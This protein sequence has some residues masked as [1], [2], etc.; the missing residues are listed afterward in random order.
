MG[1]LIELN[2]GK[3][4]Y[5]TYKK[6]IYGEDKSI[7]Y[8]QLRTTDGAEI[9]LPAFGITTENYGMVALVE[10]GDASCSITADVSG[11][12]HG[13]NHASAVF[14][15]TPNALIDTD[16]SMSAIDFQ[17]ELMSCDLSVRYM[18]LEAPY[19][20]SIMANT[21]REYLLESER[22]SLEQVK[23]TSVLNLIGAVT[24][25]KKFMGIKRYVPKALTTYSQAQEI[26][27]WFL[28]SSDSEFDVI[29]EGWGN[30]GIENRLANKALTVKELG[31]KQDFYNLLSDASD[32][33]VHVIPDVNF[34][35]VSQKNA[36]GFSERKYSA[37][38]IQGAVA[39]VVNYEYG[40]M[41]KK[42]IVGD[43]LVAP[44]KLMSLSQSFF[45]KYQQYGASDIY[46][47]AIGTDLNSDF[48]RGNL[49]DREQAKNHIRE[50]LSEVAET[51]SITVSGGNAYA[52]GYAD[53]IVDLPLQSG[54][55]YILDRDIPFLSMVLAGTTELNAL[56]NGEKSD[57]WYT[58]K[59]IEAGV[60]PQFNLIYSDTAELREC[61]TDMLLTSYMA[62]RE[63]AKDI[64]QLVSDALEKV[65]GSC[66]IGH[67]YQENGVS[68]THYENGYSV[69]VNFNDET[70]SA[71][72]K[73][74]E[75]KSWLVINERGE[76]E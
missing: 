67:E 60:W 18:V 24:Y 54:R 75:G 5:E 49:V 31:G 32:K 26:Y 33:G 38:N 30:K 4:Q 58:L 3:T 57:S 1:A 11:R 73:S 55:A 64:T 44:S 9:H 50:F 72:G 25:Q 51:Y 34:M 48:N 28:E 35:Y 43:Y 62:V 21:L 47:S 19:T 56:V 8:A 45:K 7:N 20:Y 6:Q 17:K 59:M 41:R 12:Y 2:N 13:Y 36:G 15:T 71:E 74:V 61:D 63:K 69:I 37:K 10:S 76:E 66:I 52:Y 68:I 22:L 14:L 42:D 70:Q 40:T 23:N 27:E 53:R 39:T 16:S 65:N 46:L 29:Y